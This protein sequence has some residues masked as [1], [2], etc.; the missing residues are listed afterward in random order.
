M[1]LQGCLPDSMLMRRS[2]R[3]FSPGARSGSASGPAIFGKLALSSGTA[4]AFFYADTCNLKGCVRKYSDT[5]W[6]LVHA[7]Y[8]RRVH[9]QHS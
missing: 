9:V 8:T 2:H 7:S 3:G 4:T 6:V 5:P 1:S